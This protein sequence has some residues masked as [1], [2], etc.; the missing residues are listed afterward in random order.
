MAAKPEAD[1]EPVPP[2]DLLP[3]V[4]SERERSVG[5]QLD[6]VLNA[7][8]IKALDYYKGVMHDMPALENRSK[9]VST[10]VADTIQTLMPDLIEI[11]TGGDDVASFE[12][13]NENDVAQAQQ[14]TDY[15]HHVFFKENDGF[16]NLYTFM[17]DALLCKT[18]VATWRWEKLP[19]VLGE[20]FEGK[21]RLEVAMARN[22][23][24]IEN[25]AYDGIPYTPGQILPPEASSEPLWS[26]NLKSE[27]PTGRLRIDPIAPEDFTVAKDT[28]LKV[29]DG[30]YCAWRS[31]PRAQ[32]LKADG[33]DPDIID[34]LPV[35]SISDDEQT[36]RARDTAGENTYVIAGDGATRDLRTVEVV[37]H[38]VRVLNDETNELEIWRVVTGA[39]ET[40]LIDQEKVDRIEVAAITPRIVTHRFYGESIADCLLEIQ[41][42]KTAL[43]RGQ[44]DTIYF[45]LNQRH[46]VDMTAATDFTISDLLDNRPGVPVRGRGPQAVS[47]L[48]N[49]QTPAPYLEALEYFSTV[50]E[51]RT[52]VVRNAQGLNPDT[53]HDTM[54]GALALMSMA[55]R[56]TRMIARIFAET[57]IKDLFLGIHAM[58]R[59]HSSGPSIKRLRGQWIP[60]DPTEWAE[61]ND[62]EIEIGV[63]AGGGM[64]KLGALKDVIAAQV[65]LASGPG[66]MLVT[67]QNAY[68]AVTDATKAAGL[69]SPEQYFTDPEGKTP[70]PQPNPDMM[71]IQAQQQTDQAKAQTEQGKLQL[72]QQKAQQDAQTTQAD[73][74]LR[75]KSE[76]L[77]DQRERDALA[78]DHQREMARLSSE[79]QIK[80]QE[81]GLRAREMELKHQFELVKLKQDG[82]IAIAT[83]NAQ[84]G[85]QVG[86]AQIKAASDAL[87]AHT[88]LA[89]QAME[90]HDVQTEAHADRVHDV[91]MAVVGHGLSEHG[92]DADADRAAAAPEPEPKGDE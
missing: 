10:D 48:M 31:R 83:V 92:K 21:T 74:E 80:A 14:E 38:Y 64:Q 30:T 57:G 63:G 46:Y 75:A 91:R 42:I 65:Q 62:M 32:T 89:V 9:A 59:K 71:K 85:A 36:K 24:P 77:K 16:L 20:T 44:L 4:K 69:K 56:R 26:F 47:P 7:E 23:G 50:G 28:K 13:N 61:R 76:I 72:D 54:G 5:F 53:L 34:S 52:G 29:Q 43:M 79:Q 35:H 81:L 22:D 12:P 87:K 40:I 66:A 39:N 60:V 84:T 68:N 51:Q 78:A 27:G 45:N 58:I 8:R 49:S 41:R 67:P 18:G 33:Y 73:L 17:F 2:R 15:I 70:A 3:I 82:E 55:Q 86:T 6:P 90:S 19:E 1:A 11:F 37:T 88:D 25:M